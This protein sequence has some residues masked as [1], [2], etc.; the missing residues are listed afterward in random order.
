MHTYDIDKGVWSEQ[1][2]H[3]REGIVK[4]D[5]HTYDIYWSS[6]LYLGNNNFYILL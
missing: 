6:S 1:R 4:M 5:D 3:I 2:L